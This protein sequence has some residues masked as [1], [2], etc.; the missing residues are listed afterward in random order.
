VKVLHVEAGRHLYGGAQQVLYLLEGLQR[1]GI[2][3]VLACPTGSELAERARPFGEVV[4]LPM[5]GD[6]DLGLIG[7]LHRAVRAHRP[8]V[9]HLHGRRGADVLG[10]IAS[11]LA[12]VPCVLSRRVDNPE[13]R[14]WVGLK[15][16]LYAHVIAI[17]EGI[18]DILMAEGL[19]ATR[20]TCVRSAVDPR[21]WGQGC[22]RD[23]FLREFGLPGDA[24]VAGMIA[25]FIPRKGHRHLLAAL[26][27]VLE[28]HPGLHVLLFGQG[29]LVAEVQGAIGAQ[30]LGGHVQLAGFR[31]DLARWL[32][33]LDMIVHPAER[34]GLGVSLLQA[35]AAGL[36][37]IAARAGGMPEV[38][39]DGRTGLVVAP[40]DVMALAEAMKRLLDDGAL[41]A[42]MGRRGRA[43]MDAHFSPD[44][45]VAGNLAVYRH[46]LRK[47]A[48]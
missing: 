21:A 9:V 20:V 44:A 39:E 4:T 13:S 15:Y 23:A 12:G 35:A 8:D 43:R 47:A 38:V 18:R 40:G 32:G 36:P 48:G 3:N 33:C 41:R 46:V 37:I 14:L 24:P 42:E 5:R 17:S 22:E 30:G 27:M 45:M 19:A 2:E 6:V 1:L 34:E 25:Q 16:R 10:G 7:R 29:P 31:P 11:R 28:R 26:P